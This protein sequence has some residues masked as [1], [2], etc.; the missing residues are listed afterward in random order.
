MKMLNVF[1][2]E[3]NH[4]RKNKAKVITY[5]I[6]VLACVYSLINGFDLQNRQM[7]TIGNIEQNQQKEINQVVEWF[8][9]DI[10]GPV[11][12]SWID[13]RNPYWSLSYIPTY[14]IKRPSS[15]MPLGI[16]QA[17]QYG[18]YK[19]ITSW[20]STYDQDMV[21]ELSNPERLVN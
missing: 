13:I 15:L 19:K 20:S 21:E 18:F 7:E 9:N 1:L 8:N 12:K 5:F 17:E 11:S 3:F 6:F 10:K 14:S 16:G 4:F 2:F